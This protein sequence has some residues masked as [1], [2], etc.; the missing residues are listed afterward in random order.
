M[1]RTKMTAAR[2]AELKARHEA[3][4]AA[5]ALR[6]IMDKCVQIYHRAVFIQR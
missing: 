5:A 3:V 1:T 6:L 2:R 4:R